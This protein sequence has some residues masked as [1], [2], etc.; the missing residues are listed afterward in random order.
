MSL[1]SA[2]ATKNTIAC[3]T[4][5]DL[6]MPGIALRALIS[7]SRTDA[8]HLKIHAN[9]LK[10]TTGTRT[11]AKPRQ[12][13]VALKDKFGWLT[14]STAQN[15]SMKLALTTASF[16]T[17]THRT[18]ELSLRLT[19]HHTQSL[20]SGLPPDT[21]NQ[22]RPDVPLRSMTVEL[23]LAEISSNL[24]ATAQPTAR[25]SSGSTILNPA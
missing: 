2:R 21:A 25:P 20:E 22:R 13:L 10:S 5:A 24:I 16:I 9:K 12:L 7:G 14:F 1:T 8:C 4:D 18:V 17:P 19:V 11:T 6:S 3:G 15:H 23:K